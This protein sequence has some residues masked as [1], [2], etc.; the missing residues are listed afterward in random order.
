[1]KIPSYQ[2][3]I[4][5]KENDWKITP[6]Y[7][8]AM[9]KPAGIGGL[10]N[11]A[12]LKKDGDK[13]LE[14]LTKDDYKKYD[15]ISFDTV[16]GITGSRYGLKEMLGT[17]ATTDKPITTTDSIV[18]EFTGKLDANNTTGTADQLFELVFESGIDDQVSDKLNVDALTS[19][20]P[21]Y[22]DYTGTAPIQIENRK[23]EY[24][25]TGGR[26][27]LIFT[28]AGLALMSAAAYVYS[29]KRGVS[30]DE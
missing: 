6:K 13:T 29:R 17:T 25:L 11:V 30:Y 28:L 3:Y 12:V 5:I 27:T 4:R 23:A 9:N 20:K 1:M 21:S 14:N 8:D 2:S 19:G 7:K 15:A 18:M 26:G 22:G 16:G 24:P 10:V